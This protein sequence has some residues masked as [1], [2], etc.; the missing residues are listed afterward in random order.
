MNIFHYFQ[1]KDRKFFPL[2]ERSAANVTATSKMLVELV[3]TQSPDRRKEVFREIERL[4]HVGDEITHET[5]NELSKNFITPFDREDIHDL[6]AAI[7]DIVD[8][9][10]GAAKRIEL[11]KVETMTPAIV[12]LSELIQQS[13]EELEVAVSELKNMRNISK[14]KESCVRINSI[15]NHA[16]DIFDMAIAKLFEEEKNAVEVIKM[17]D[18]LS[19]LEIATDK[20]EDAANIISTIL[21]K[22]A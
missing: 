19:V 17:K 20:A 8:F 3:T 7:D 10:H 12:K 15:E 1:P 21:V 22:N 16:D 18:I 2:F 14:I 9:I 6:V 13:S 5:F 4:E 11:Y